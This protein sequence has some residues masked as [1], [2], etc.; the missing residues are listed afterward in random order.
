MM[1]DEFTRLD[2]D[3]EGDGSF[4]EFSENIEDGQLIKVAALPGGMKSGLPSVAL[5]TKTIID[6]KEKYVIGQT[7]MK[8]FLMAADIFRKK[9]VVDP[10]QN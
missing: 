7:S 5:L 9:F 6:G 3:L 2:V 1:N 10:S 4:R 8:M